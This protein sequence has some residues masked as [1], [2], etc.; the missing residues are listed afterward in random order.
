MWGKRSEVNLEV[1]EMD[2][3]Y[4]LLVFQQVELFFKTSAG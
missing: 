1:R 4:I 3:A 2:I